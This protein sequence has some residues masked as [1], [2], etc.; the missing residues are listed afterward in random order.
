METT[1]RPTNFVDGDEYPSPVTHVIGFGYSDGVTSGVLKTA[2][3][4]VYSFDMT[5]DEYNA[6]GLDLRTF[7]L[8]PLAAGAFADIVS[9][10]E[11]HFE[12]CWPCWVPVWT[13][14]SEES[15]TATEARIDRVLMTAG[16]PVWRVES[17]DLTETVSAS[18]LT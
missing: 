8:A 4:S 9:A 1:T 7:E 13:F 6:D 2:D 10:L 18:V 11:R 5:G 14:P 17:R 3:A 15:R 12:P 16:K